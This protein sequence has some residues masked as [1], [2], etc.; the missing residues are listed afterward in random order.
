MNKYI[1]LSVC[2][3]SLLLTSCFNLDLNPLSEGSSENW[4]S[5]EEELN[6]SAR[7]MYA[8][9]Y[10]NNDGDAYTDNWTSRTDLSGISDGTLNGQS[11][12][13]KNMWEYS[14]EAIAR[15]N[16]LLENIQHARDNGVREDFLTGIEGEA[17]FVRAAQYAR[18]VAHFGD[19]VYPHGSITDLDEAFKMGRT[20]K[21]I[22]IK[23]IYEDFDAA[24][25]KLNVQPRTSELRATKG[26]AYA[27][28]ARAA[29]YNGDYDVA[30]EAS[31]K[32]MDL[33]C[34]DLHPDFG[35]LFLGATKTSKEFIFMI[36]RSVELGFKFGTRTYVS[37]CA[38]GFAQYCPSWDLMCAFLCSDGLPIDES[39]LYNPQQPFKNRDPRCAE[40]IVEFGTPFL[41]YD[42][43]P[44]PYTTTVTEYSTGK[45]VSNN[46]NR[47]INQYASFNG[48][49]WKKGVD[50]SWLQNSFQTDKNE[51]IMRYAEVLLIYAEAK[52]EMNDID[53]SVLDAINKVR[54]RAYGVSVS[55]T[56][57]YPAVTVTDPAKLRSIIR[58]E[59]RM[60]FANEGLYYMD[61]I[62]WRIAEK[63][64][65]TPV[66]GMLDPADL[67][68]KV[69]DR[70]L[71]FFPGTPDV[72]ENAISDFSAMYQA[73]LIKLLV[74]RK[75]DS[76]RQY[77]WPIP[78]KE[79]LINENLKPQNPGY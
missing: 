75:F 41:G 28:K 55:D 31:K 7:F 14:Y 44:N 22:V 56:D 38:K 66:F 57:K 58:F 61:I 59:R 50:E 19:V 6:M 15:A 36:P 67:M 47:V 69:V 54:A 32:C 64:L 4:Y 42:Y 27:F 24:A 72:D 30:A 13:V 46:D 18:L 9:K 21:E 33:D 78:T 43:D 12:S 68:T 51:I 40:T 25:D 73:G 26:M 45:T 76:S 20:D 62:R 53:Q 5:T 60:E 1:I 71:W 11:G 34:Y 23:G 52:I 37:R 74:Q 70:G 8:N 16:N 35:N 65:N 29:I 10:W 48:L 77:L 63:S 79:I 3:M 39:P 2:G 49:L 17:L